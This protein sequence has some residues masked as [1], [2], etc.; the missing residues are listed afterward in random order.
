MVH[1]MVKPCFSNLCNVSLHC[2]QCRCCAVQR[3]YKCDHNVHNVRARKS[4]WNIHTHYH[5]DA[6]LCCYWCVITVI[7]REGAWIPVNWNVKKYMYRI[8]LLNIGVSL[9]CEH[10]VW[11]WWIVFIYKV[12]LILSEHSSPP[13]IR[14]LVVRVVL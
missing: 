7:L 11:I 12:N 2:L 13:V 10:E 14:T 5:F 3:L 8:C 1:L 4:F 9:C 6:I